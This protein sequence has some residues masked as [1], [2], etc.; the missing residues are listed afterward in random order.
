MSPVKFVKKGR[1]NALEVPSIQS[2]ASVKQEKNPSISDSPKMEPPNTF[3]S[4]AT[5]PGKSIVSTCKSIEFMNFEL[6]NI[7]K[8]IESKQ[9]CNQICLITVQEREETTTQA[10]SQD[11]AFNPNSNGDGRM[12]KRMKMCASAKEE[13]DKCKSPKESVKL[14]RTKSPKSAWSKSK[15]IM[16]CLICQEK[17]HG[18]KDCPKVKLD[19]CCFKCGATDHYARA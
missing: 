12:L 11:E 17:G 7:P 6:I 1:S 16:R 13:E 8:F 3:A 19:Q 4:S 5:L 2:N 9:E 15:K 18:L 10:S 14:E